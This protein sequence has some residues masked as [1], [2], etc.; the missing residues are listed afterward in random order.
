L[1]LFE[2]VAEDKGVDVDAATGAEATVQID[3]REVER[4][5]SLNALRG[6]VMRDFDVGP[7]SSS[8]LGST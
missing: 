1:E 2:L 8:Q 4:I 6:L 3:G 7:E 5:S